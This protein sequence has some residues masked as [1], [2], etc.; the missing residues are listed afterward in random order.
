MTGFEKYYQEVESLSQNYEKVDAKCRAFAEEIERYQTQKKELLAHFGTKYGNV[1]AG[2]MRSYTEEELLKLRTELANSA[3]LLALIKSM[4]GFGKSQ[5]YF[6]EELMGKLNGLLSYMGKQLRDCQNEEKTIINRLY[7]ISQNY[8]REY[9]QARNYSGSASDSD[10][11]RFEMPPELEKGNI[12]LGDILGQISNENFIKLLSGDEEREPL[13]SGCHSGGYLKMPHHFDLSSPISICVDY[14]ADTAEDARLLLQSL[15]YQIVRNAPQYYMEFHFMDAVTSGEDFKDFIPLQQVRAQ[16]VAAFNQKVTKGNYRLA[17]TYLKAEDIGRGL[18]ELNSRSTI[19]INE[20]A[21]FTTVTEYNAEMG[22]EDWI[23]YQLVVAQNL[24]EGFSDIDLK[25]LQFLIENGN[26][27]GIFVILMNNTER[28]NRGEFEN[29]KSLES[30]FTPEALQSL[31]RIKLNKSK[32]LITVNGHTTEF[33]PWHTGTSHKS[34]IEQAVTALNSESELDNSFQKVMD[35]NGP[36][37]SMTSTDGIRIPFAITGRGKMMEYVL[38][39]N[40]NAHGLI[41]GGTGSGKSSLLHML[42]SSI[43]INYSPEDVE[44]WLAD[45]KITE[46]SS[47][48]TNTPP[49]IRFVGLSKTSDFSYA[50]LDKIVAEMDRRQKLITQADQMYKADG[51]KDNITS[52][53]DY[54][55]M[56]GRDS[57]RRLVIIIDEFHV[58]SQHAQLEPDYKIKLEN[59]LSEARALGI[60]MV[61]SDQAI[62]DGLRGLSDKGKKQIKARIALSNYMDELKETLNEDD[63]EKLRSFVHM[64]VGEVAVQTVKEDEDRQEV[65]TVQR[66]KSIYINSIC[67][68]NVNEKA[69]KIYHAEN[70]C[71]DIFDDQVIEAMNMEEIDRWEKQNLVFRR[72]GKRDLHIYLGRPV[73]LDFALHF[74]LQQRKGNNMMCMSGTEEQQMRVMKSVINSFSRQKEYE[75]L[76]LT[77]L[78]AGLYREY[79]PEIRELAKKNE[80]IRVFDNLEDICREIQ[81]LLKL[82][83]NR[84]NTKRC[85][86]IWLGLDSM[87]DILSEERNK[88][89]NDSKAGTARPVKSAQFDGFDLPNLDFPSEEQT[90]NTI[91]NDQGAKEDSL[92]DIFSSLFGDEDF[93]SKEESSADAETHVVE[94]TC[95]YDAREDIARLIHMGPVSNIFHLVIYDSALALRDFRDVKTSDFIHKIAFPM[96]EYEAGEFLEQSRRIREL[97]DYLGYYYNGRQG[98]RF[99]PY[100]L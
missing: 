87:A 11:S 2:E 18:T 8:C 39:Q 72:D 89:W 4:L 19:V 30:C 59:I 57:M 71:A 37:G 82:L 60:S 64:K 28:W 100:K 45:Y 6:Y 96:S 76:I 29:T 66:G 86:V 9:K 24:Q 15:I 54:R 10:W 77:D 78:F 52:F 61:F 56:N 21:Q 85:L 40:M 95:L 23:P 35:I 42:I 34:F 51:G 90:E 5:R 14:Q 65:P 88:R 46:F 55:K 12:Y 32:H 74:P 7:E 99:I 62:V 79:E 22:A 3:G 48:K 1:R 93:E 68:Y 13:F 25:N 84:G 81:N 98:K 69:R 16:D 44:L 38:G 75:I 58:M 20:K 80:C 70:Y 36:W 27:L 17:K 63:R 26:N 67:R 91:L 47:Y 73:D 50:F 83:A 49:H 92:M 43:V 31:S 33:I 97:A 53:S 41:C 94:E